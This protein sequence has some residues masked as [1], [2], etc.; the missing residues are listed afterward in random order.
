MSEL[1]PTLADALASFGADDAVL[2]V[3]L[4][5][6]GT[7]APLVDD[8]TTSTM[9]PAARDAVDTLA[10]TTADHVLLAF[11]SGRD[12]DDLALRAEPPVGSYLVGS[13]GAQTGHATADGLEAVPLELTAEQAEALATLR[14]DLDAAVEGR[15]GAW[16]QHKPSAVVLHT[17]QAGT[18]DTHAAIAAADA[19]AARLGLEA[20]HGKDVVEI[21][22]VH[23]S[24]GLALDRL[25]DVVAHDVPGPDGA[26]RR[27]RVLYAGD[28]TTDETAFAVLRPGDVGIKVGHG[29]TVA[30]HR[31]ADADDVATVLR[32]L[33]TA[34]A[35]P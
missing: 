16:V 24:K 3:A 30:A 9:T 25:R 18:E 5:F 14:H 4:D 15:D 11:V 12:L 21:A 2:L 17:R 28:D 31:V 35:A 7:L 26:T 10:T 6:D 8:P 23:T 29:D 20:M 34:T 32:H 33:V 13:H 27:V 1:D 22:V 19:A